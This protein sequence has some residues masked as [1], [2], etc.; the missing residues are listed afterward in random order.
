MRDIQRSEL[1]KNLYEL[2][3]LAAREF[4]TKRNDDVCL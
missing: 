2:S 4:T 3:N 1:I